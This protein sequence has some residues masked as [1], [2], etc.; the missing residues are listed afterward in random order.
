[1]AKER[2]LGDRFRTDVVRGAGNLKPVWAGH[3]PTIRTTQRASAGAAGFDT[4]PCVLR[5]GV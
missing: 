2:P 1:L 4:H 3:H 5:Y